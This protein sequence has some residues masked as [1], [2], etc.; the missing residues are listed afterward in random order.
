MSDP[1]STMLADLLSWYP[2]GSNKK[3]KYMTIKS[4]MPF[5]DVWHK[6]WRIRGPEQAAWASVF[7]QKRCCLKTA[8]DLLYCPQLKFIVCLDISGCIS[9]DATSLIDLCQSFQCLEVFVYRDCVNVSQYNLQRFVELCPQLRYID[10]INAGIVSITVA[11]GV[12]SVGRHLQMVWIEPNVSDALHW[13]LIAFQYGRISFGPSVQELLPCNTTLAG[14][15][16]LI[17]KEF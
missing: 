4:F 5:Q 8:F 3:L 16:Q 2:L 6:I 10:G 1:P 17:K 12:I 11:I 7:L 15:Q 9:F 14:F 13:P